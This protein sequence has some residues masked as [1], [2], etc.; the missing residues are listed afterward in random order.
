MS[1][2]DRIAEIE[3]LTVLEFKDEIRAAIQN[4][5][6]GIK[7]GHSIELLAVALNIGMLGGELK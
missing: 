2:Q 3:S 1:E 7:P 6:D 4:M 5:K